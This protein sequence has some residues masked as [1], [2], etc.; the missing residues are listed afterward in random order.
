MNKIKTAVV[1]VLTVLMACANKTGTETASQP[2]KTIN[3]ENARVFVT[4]KDTA[5]RLSQTADLAFEEFG[6]P[7]E[8]QVCVFVDPTHTFQT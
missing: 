1:L 5:L 8:T 3:P 2:A 4:A 6:Q 7:F